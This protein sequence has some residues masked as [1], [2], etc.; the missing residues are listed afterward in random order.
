VPVSSSP[1]KIRVTPLR[2]ASGFLSV[3]TS[4]A[5][6]TLNPYSYACRAVDSTPRLGGYAGDHDLHNTQVL[7]V[8]LEAPVGEQ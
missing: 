2:C 7:Q 1:G 4:T 6:V 8:R 3:M 5:G